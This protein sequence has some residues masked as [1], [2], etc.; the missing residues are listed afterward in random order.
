MFAGSHKSTLAQL[1]WDNPRKW[2]LDLSDTKNCK[3]PIK[4][5][6]FHILLNHLMINH[7]ILVLLLLLLS[8]ENVYIVI[9]CYDNCNRLNY[10]LEY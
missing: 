8:D 5:S 9:Q 2:S 1:A 3:Y 6:L 10:E 7:T 4:L